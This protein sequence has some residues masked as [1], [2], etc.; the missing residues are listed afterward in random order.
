MEINVKWTQA[1]V[2]DSGRRMP[3][4]PPKDG[5]IVEYSLRHLAKT[6]KRF[7]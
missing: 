3:R 1:E 2:V 6:N 4:V 5:K 7:R